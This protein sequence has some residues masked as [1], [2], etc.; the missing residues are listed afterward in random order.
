MKNSVGSLLDECNHQIKILAITGIRSEYDL[1]YPILSTLNRSQNFQLNIAVTGS[2]LTAIHDFSVRQIEEDGFDIVARISRTINT[3]S[4]LERARGCAELMVGLTNLLEENLPDLLL[5]LGDREEP[6]VAAVTANYIGVPVV[7]LAGGDSTRPADGNI[8]EQA[9][10]ATTKLSHI[11]L[12]MTESHSRRILKLGEESWRVKTVGSGGIDKLRLTPIM[13]RTDLSNA[14]GL[15]CDREYVVLIHHALNGD[16]CTAIKDIE[17]MVSCARALGLQTIIGCPNSDPGAIEL[18]EFCEQLKGVDLYKNL[19]RPI[20]VNLLRHSSLL[21]GNSSA[22]FHEAD[23]LG[24][25]AINVGERQ[26]HREHS[27]NVIF[28]DNTQSSITA[29]MNRALSN[30]EFQASL[31][32]HQSLYGDGYTAEKVVTILE[33]LPSKNTLLAKK[34]TY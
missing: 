18:I 22:A 4:K 29:A 9:R 12:T 24:L 14:T 17:N 6:L 26:L 19:P 1:M 27:G 28:S 33:N 31:H 8:D 5:V 10:H 2:H 13:S 15:R 3:C 30:K 34:L 21:L 7:H 11:H 25:P 16:Y 23:Y 20:F 32:P